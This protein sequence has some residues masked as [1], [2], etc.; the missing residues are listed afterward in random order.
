MCLDCS[1]ASNNEAKLY[2]LKR[3]LKITKRERF[4][5]SEVEGDS[6]LAIEMVKKL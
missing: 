3:G 6:K 5:R 4:Q 2:A 1:I